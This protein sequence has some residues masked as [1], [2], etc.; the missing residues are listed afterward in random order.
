MEEF[1]NE[2]LK[3]NFLIAIQVNNTDPELKSHLL[4]FKKKDVMV[5][6]DRVSTLPNELVQN[7]TD[8]LKLIRSIYKYKP[9]YSIS[10]AAVSNDLYCKI[11]N[12]SEDDLKMLI[13]NN[14]REL[15][16]EEEFGWF[17]YGLDCL[18]YRIPKELVVG[19]FEYDENSDTISFINNNNYY[20]N[21]SDEDRKS[22]VEI[23]KELITEEVENDNHDNEYPYGNILEL[24]KRSN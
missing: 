4:G 3:N 13:N 21:L 1:V 12:L 22:F 23:Y 8:F 14:T 19:S 5:Y 7:G 17:T 11:F 2:L 15:C 6:D 20:M 10:V 18:N 9:F 24:R 16:I